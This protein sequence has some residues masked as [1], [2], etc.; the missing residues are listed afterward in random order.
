MFRFLP[1]LSRFAASRTATTLLAYAFF[2]LDPKA[3]LQSYVNHPVRLLVQNSVQS[4]GA[5]PIPT[6]RQAKINR[7][8]HVFL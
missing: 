3:E 2:E 8:P 5:F 7:Y 6:K 4:V 1:I